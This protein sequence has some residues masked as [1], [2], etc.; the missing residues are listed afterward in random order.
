MLKGENKYDTAENYSILFLIMGSVT[1]AAGILLN[2]VSTVGISAILS[3]FG[4]LITFI[5]TVALVF[6]WLLKEMFGE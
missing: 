6:V 1:L 2:I 3:M 5:A 4:T